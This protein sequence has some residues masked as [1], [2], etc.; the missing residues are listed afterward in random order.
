MYRE[1]VKETTNQRSWMVPPKRP[2]WGLLFTAV[3]FAVCSMHAQAAAQQISEHEDPVSDERPTD[4][5]GDEAADEMRERLLFWLNSYHGAPS[6]EQLESL[7]EPAA[8]AE[9]LR[10]LC[11]DA[12]LRPS[13]RVRAIDGLGFFDESSTVEFLK[14]IVDA[15]RQALEAPRRST[16]ERFQ[17]H[18]MRS[19]ARIQ[20]PAAVETLERFLEADDLQLRISAVETIGRFG[21]QAG[22]LRLERLGARVDDPVLERKIEAFVGSSPP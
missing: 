12:G 8:V 21:G 18:A 20:G 16:A 11:A 1:R 10:E 7:G 5:P 22:R 3:V 4:K 19:F 15:P 2:S 9:G 6:G 17:R 13:L 14:E